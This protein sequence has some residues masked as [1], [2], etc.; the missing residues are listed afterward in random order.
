MD[1]EA[2]T[3]LLNEDLSSEYQSIVQYNLHISTVTGP[4]FVSTI[5][6]LTKHLF[7]EL[8]HARVLATQVSFLGGKPTTVVPDIPVTSDSRSALEADL[9]L[10]QRQ[11]ERYRERFGQA[12]DL[13]L[14]DVG[15]ALRPLLEQTQEHVQDLLTALGR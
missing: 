12:T 6:E 8:N 11:L 7:E 13:G 10:E 2:F 9:E 5:E 4:E 14:V 1:K 15:E 3:D